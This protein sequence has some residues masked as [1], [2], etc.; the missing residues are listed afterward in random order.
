MKTSFILLSLAQ[1][2]SFLSLAFICVWA[3]S[4]YGQSDKSLLE[5]EIYKLDNG[6]TIYLN[7]DHSLP[8][9]IGAVAVKGGSKRDPADATGIAHYFEHIMFKGTDQMGTLDY[10]SEKVYLDSI[11]GLYDK[12]AMTSVAEEKAT[13]QPYRMK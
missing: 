10:Q 3:L 9:V 8:S 11:A 1:K 7:E 2:R 5:T 12:L 6:L 4:S 13:I